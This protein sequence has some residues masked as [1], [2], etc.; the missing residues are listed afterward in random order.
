MELIV[1]CVC[2]CVCV[3]SDENL[4]FCFYFSSFLTGM[5]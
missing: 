2:V 4:Q 3:L 1:L 5:K